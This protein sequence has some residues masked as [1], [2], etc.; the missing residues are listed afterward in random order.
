MRLPIVALALGLLAGCQ[1]LPHP[2]ADQAHSPSL[3]P[4]RPR[5]S[6]GITVLPVAA[7][8]APEEHPLADALV[9]ALLAHDMLAST[10]A[11]NR[12]SFRL[13]TSVTAAPTSAGGLH[14]TLNWRLADPKGAKLGEGIV[15]DEATAAS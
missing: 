1:P 8:G 10:D 7:A 11:T 6:V 9:H 2:F 12:G 13:S 4:L 14:V 3:P 15:E 5:D